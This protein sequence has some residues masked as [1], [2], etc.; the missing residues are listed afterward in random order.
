MEINLIHKK[1][2]RTG[3][4]YYDVQVDRANILGRLRVSDHIKKGSKFN[5]LAYKPKKIGIGTLKQFVK[6]EIKR[7]DA[8]EQYNR[9]R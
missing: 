8:L 2:A 5:F 4:V 7:Q 3:T 1:V 9:I 6:D